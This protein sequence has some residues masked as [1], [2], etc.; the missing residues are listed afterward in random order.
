ME[1]SSNF[2]TRNVFARQPDCLRDYARVAT[3]SLRMARCIRISKLDRMNKQF[4]QFPIGGFELM[5]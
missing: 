2:N 4:E 1:H 5:L 3:D